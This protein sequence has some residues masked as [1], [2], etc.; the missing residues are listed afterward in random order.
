MT[1]TWHWFVIVQFSCCSS[2]IRSVS[3][4]RSLSPHQWSFHIVTNESPNT[5]L[6]RPSSR[7]SV[8]I[9][10]TK[11]RLVLT[12]IWNTHT[13]AVDHSPWSRPSCHGNRGRKEDGETERAK[14]KY[15]NEE[16]SPS[17]ACPPQRLPVVTHLVSRCF[18]LV[19]LTALLL[20]TDTQTEQIRVYL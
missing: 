6:H 3:P 20:S 1:G 11:S 7:S 10:W 17:L 12:K 2:Y 18:L 14:E 9:L 16:K 15:M 4:G 8:I 19:H 5:R 13:H